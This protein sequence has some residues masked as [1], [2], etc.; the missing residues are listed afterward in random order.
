MDI[1]A[2]KEFHERLTEFCEYY[3]T[4]GIACVLISLCLLLLC[5]DNILNN[6][7]FTMNF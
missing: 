6:K 4:L 7:S 3:S 5:Y 1:S 2:A